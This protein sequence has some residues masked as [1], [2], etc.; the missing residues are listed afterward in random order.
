MFYDGEMLLAHYQRW[1]NTYKEPIEAKFAPCMQKSDPKE[2]VKMAME[3]MLTEI[4][5]IAMAEMIM[6]NNGRLEEAVSTAISEGGC[7]SCATNIVK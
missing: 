3:V 1:L 7:S 4:F 5:P 6:F 2:A